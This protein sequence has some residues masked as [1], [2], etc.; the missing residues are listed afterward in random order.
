MQQHRGKKSCL[1]SYLRGESLPPGPGQPARRSLARRRVPDTPPSA[2]TPR[3]APP[4][5]P[6]ASLLRGLSPAVLGPAAS[7]F[8]G[9]MPAVLGAAASLFR[10]LMPAVLGPAA[11]GPSRQPLRAAAGRF[12][13]LPLFVCAGRAIPLIPASGPDSPTP[14]HW[15]GPSGVAAAA[16]A[17]APFRKGK[18]NENR[19]LSAYHLPHR[20][21]AGKRE[22]G[23][24]SS[25]GM[26]S[27]PPGGSQGRCAITAC[28]ITAS[29]C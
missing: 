8:R 29:T 22:S 9:L 20:R 4:D 16:A 7:L 23:P 24:G 21:R 17:Q 25:R 10:G 11:P 27:M 26:P 6:A 14:A 18:A 19:S 28:P 5:E 3:N 2:G 12:P 13:A 1:L 15:R